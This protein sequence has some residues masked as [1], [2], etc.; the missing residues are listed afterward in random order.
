MVFYEVIFDEVWL[1]RFE[2]LVNYVIDYFFD[3]IIYFFNYIFDFDFF[4]I[5]RKKELGDGVIFSFNFLMVRVLFVLGIYLYE[6]E[7]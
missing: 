7:Y 1:E 4:L 2:D 3:I 6:E 5:V